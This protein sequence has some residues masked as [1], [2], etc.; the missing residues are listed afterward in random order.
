MS[1]QS[2]SLYC[3]LLAPRQ[4]HHYL[5]PDSCQSLLPVSTLSS[6]M[7][8]QCSV[9]KAQTPYHSLQSPIRYGL[10]YSTWQNLLLLSLLVT[11]CSTH[12]SH[13]S[14]FKHT[15]THSL[16]WNFLFV[17][18][19]VW[20]TSSRGL[21]LHFHVL[22]QMSPYQRGIPWQSYL[23]STNPGNFLS[24]PWFNI[25]RYIIEN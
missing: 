10:F 18:P 20:K 5:S 12:N 2:I 7:A 23:S 16:L 17:V 11:I 24:L 1:N 4:S 9:N 25:F 19:S 8:F 22:I 21:L 3:P 15:Q 6:V 13:P 14:V